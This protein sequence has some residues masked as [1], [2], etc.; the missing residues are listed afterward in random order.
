M[1]VKEY[2]REIYKYRS[3][4]VEEYRSRGEEEKII[5]VEE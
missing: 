1:R 3:R 4:G 2:R 5:E